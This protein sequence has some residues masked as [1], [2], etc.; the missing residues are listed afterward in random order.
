MRLSYLKPSAHHYKQKG[1]SMQKI[2][3]DLN[4]REMVVAAFITEDKEGKLRVM[5]YDKNGMLMFISE[6]ADSISIN[7]RLGGRAIRSIAEMG[8]KE[9]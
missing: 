2:I 8:T 7:K 9:I 1:E 3:D 5:S 4:D 6:E